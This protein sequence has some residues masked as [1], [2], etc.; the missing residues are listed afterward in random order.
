MRGTRDAAG[1]WHLVADGLVGVAAL[2]F[3]EKLVPV[4]PSHVLYVFVGMTFAATRD[5]LVGIALASALGS[6][7]GAACWYLL[8]RMLGRRRAEIA[9]R[10]LR[11][12]PV[13][14]PGELRTHR[15]CVLLRPRA[16][17]DARRDARVALMARTKNPARAGF[18]VK[19]MRQRVSA[20]CDR[21]GGSSSAAPRKAAGRGC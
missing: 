10:T 16:S 14:R 20:A 9:V 12:L 21:R 18:F 11:S 4:M 19:A 6:T 2:A 7:L 5:E 3:V 1:R 17:R 13:R 8:G 15:E